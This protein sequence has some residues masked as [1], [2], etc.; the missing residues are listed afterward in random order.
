MHPP[1]LILSLALMVLVIFAPVIAD[2]DSG[3]GVVSGTVRLLGP[4][5]NILTVQ[6]EVDFDACGTEARQTKSLVLGTNQSVRDVIIY[7]GGYAPSNI[8]SDTND[9][10]V[11]DQ[12]NCEFVP[13]IQIARSGTPLILTE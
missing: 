12:R 11:L 4:A 9:A 5:P 10:A 13:R 1:K 8:T 7:L 2:G 6:P 3:E